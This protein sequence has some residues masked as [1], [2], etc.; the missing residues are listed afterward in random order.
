ML[1]NLASHGLDC[2]SGPVSKI[3]SVPKFIPVLCFMLVDLMD[4]NEMNS[5]EDKVRNSRYFG[6][7]H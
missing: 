4:R 7:D 3:I 6:G 1:F 2:S 5:V